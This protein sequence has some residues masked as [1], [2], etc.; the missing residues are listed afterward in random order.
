MHLHE[1]PVPPSQRTSRDIP[2]DLEEIIMACLAKQP[3]LRPQSAEAMSEMLARCEG[4]GAW[5]KAQARE[6]WVENRSM[7]P[8]EEHEE[9]HSPLSNTQLL[10]DEDAQSGP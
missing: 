10:V 5:T 6:W 4:L 1:E 3:E 8:M 7:L 9:T 2:P